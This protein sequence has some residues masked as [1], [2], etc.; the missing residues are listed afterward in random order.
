MNWSTWSIE[1][2][3]FVGFGLVLVLVVVV[4]IIAVQST[5]QLIEANRLVS[6]TLEVIAELERVNSTLLEAETAQRAYIFTEYQVYFDAYQTASAAA[7]TNAQQLRTL[8]T[9]N[10]NQQRQMDALE[11]LIAERIVRLQTGIDLWLSDGFD[12][13]RT[14]IVTDG[15]VV[16][17][18]ISTLIDEM[19]ADERNLLAQRRNNAETTAEGTFVAFTAFIALTAGLLAYMYY[20]IRRDINA[21]KQA[22]IAAKAAQDYTANI[23]NTVREP[24]LVLDADLRVIS[25]NRTFYTT[26]NVKE[27][28]TVSAPIYE[29]GNQQW[30]IPALRQLLEAILPQNAEFN[31]FEVEQDFPNIGR[32]TML[33]NARKIYRPGNHTALILLAMENVTSRKQA[34]T[35]LLESEEQ[36][37]AT[38]EQAA[39]GI[40]HI[41]LDGRWLRVNQKLCDII[42]YTSD[43]LHEKTFQEITHPDDLEKDLT[44]VQ[45]V[46]AGEIQ[47]YSMEKRYIHKDQSYVWINLTVSLVRGSSGAPKYFISVIE[48]IS[49][50]KRL[51]QAMRESDE[52]H[53]NLFETMAQGVV[54]QDGEGKITEANPAAQRILG[55]T[56]SQM[57]GDSP[58]DPRW[59]LIHEDGSDYPIEMHPT[60]LA[61][62]TGQPMH[63]VVMGVFSPQDES[64]HW[65]EVNA[66][67]QFRPGEEKPW[68][69][70][71]TFTD[72]TLRRQ[73][74]REIE[75]LNAVLE[76]RAVELEAT[77]KELEAF[78]YSVSHDLRAPLRSIDGFSQALLED[79]ADQIDD[80]G[81]DY[82]QRVR[83]AANRMA[84]LIDD[85]LNLSRITRAEMRLE[86]VDLSDMAQS[87]ASDL[88][89]QQPERQV[90]FSIRDGMIVDGD[91]RLMRVALENLIGNAWKFTSKRSQAHIE[92]G[93]VDQPEDG[94]VFYVRDDGD[95]FDMAYVD[96]LFGAFQRLHAITEFEGTGIGLATVQRVIRRHGGNVWAQGEIGKGAI[97][98]FRL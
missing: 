73:A 89:Q 13:V 63:E 34:E 86:P 7:V 75:E 91:P 59:H 52:K 43:E 96:K 30:D 69:V 78:S 38:F 6:H 29:L 24:L 50:R 22:E 20:L 27:T 25:A 1:R 14:Y 2:K 32:R 3:T 41:G 90:E 88:Q 37:R 11:P 46:L 23:V 76:Q 54:Y 51:E 10:P 42:G 74:M 94:R 71:G 55:M 82:L 5:R 65:I 33:L 87:I 9:D 70:Y 79:Y 36:L 53:R 39:V 12:R 95:G 35:R 48:D 44:Y 31:D 28:E 49:E 67:P 21:R 60:M 58:T 77:N 83:A 80:F 17:Q 40:A 81:K 26:F 62:Q 85:L 84:A 19:Q 56:L 92:F 98:F 93:M 8:T 66:A 68:Q 57:Q 64:I 47:N 97:F 16:A 4:G 18:Q 72:I 45:A 15:G 61:F